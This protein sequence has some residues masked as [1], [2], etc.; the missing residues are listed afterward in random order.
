MAFVSETPGVLW[1]TC[2]ALLAAGEKRLE[3]PI[4]LRA[5]FLA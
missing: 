2:R 5:S 1:E 3:F 4:V